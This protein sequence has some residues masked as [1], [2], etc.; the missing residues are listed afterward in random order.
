MPG[1]LPAGMP[2][3]KAS[4]AARPPADAPIPTIGHPGWPDAGGGSTSTGLALLLVA[5]IIPF[6]FSGNGMLYP[7]K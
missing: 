3:K 4:N 5:A 6:I 1:S 7:L 2:E